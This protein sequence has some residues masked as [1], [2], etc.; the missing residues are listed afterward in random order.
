M[1]NFGNIKDTFNNILSNSLLN[2]DEKGKKL[3]SKYVNTLKEDTKLRNEY[4]IYKNLT[5]VK[6]KNE[7]DARYF[8][9]ENIELL[10]NNDSSKGIEKLESLLEGKDMVVD[11]NEIYNHIDTL[12]NTEKT[13]ETLIKIQESINYLT[14]H[15]LKEVVIV[16][17]EFESVDIP[18]SVLTKMATN[19]FN[20]KYQ[21]ITEGEKE[22]IKTI[23]NGDDED[24]KEVY[25]NL[26]TECIDIIDKKLN[27]NVDLDIK[28]KLLKVKDK[29]LRMTYNPDE[30]V[31]DIN[32]VYELKNSVATEE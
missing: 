27:E 12:R 11:N 29:L 5:S 3:F 30:Y 31:K 7:S 21:D 32:N 6:F 24:K 4:L 23:L 22:I 18:P 8:I 28:D 2:K 13:P 10:K 25:N 14:E 19:R 16:E 26:K 1:N 9:K 17:N 15:M 20:L